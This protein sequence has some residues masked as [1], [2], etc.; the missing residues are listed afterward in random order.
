LNTINVYD[1]SIAFLRCP[2]A[3]A[4]GGIRRPELI[5]MAFFE[6]CELMSEGDANTQGVDKYYRKISEC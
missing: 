6:L 3:S 4:R 2:K 1:G 5:N